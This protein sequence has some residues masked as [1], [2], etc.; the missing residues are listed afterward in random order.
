MNTYLLTWNPSKW[1]FHQLPEALRDV[2]KIGFYE[3]AWACV[4]SRAK[5]GDAVLLKK[6]GKGAKGLFASGVITSDPFRD[7]HFSDAASGASKRYVTVRFDRILDFSKG[8]ILP[9]K[10][11]QEFGFVPQASGCLL[12]AD[13]ADQLQKKFA[14]YAEAFVKE[15]HA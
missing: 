7:A 12:S 14:T 13:R 1:D 2:S 15:P 5:R 4:N 3:M 11:K 10:D 8:H 9:V 6:T